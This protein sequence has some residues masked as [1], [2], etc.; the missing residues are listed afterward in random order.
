[1]NFLQE[2]NLL[3]PEQIGFRKN[4]RTTDHLFI[5]KNLMDRYK[6][7]K[8][9]LFI[10]F[11]DFQKAFDTVWHD[12]LFFKL[13]NYGISSKFYSVIRTMYKNVRLAVQ[14]NGALTP[15]FQS[16]VGVRQGD[17]LS[18]SLFNLFINDLP[19]I[20]K[21]CCPAQFG[22]MSLP[23]LLYADDLAIFSESETGMQRALHNLGVY[24]KKWKLTV[25]TTKTKIMII[26]KPPKIGSFLLSNKAID[27]VESYSYLGIE[28]NNS[29]DFE[30]AKSNLY[31]KGL[32]VYFKLV[33]SMSPLPKAS[34]M[35]HL[36]DHL[37]K[38]IL[39]YN[40]EIWG[41]N[42]RQ[43]KVLIS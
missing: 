14:C 24:C 42:F 10:C 3:A 20:F 2:R 31:K 15:F 9:S 40:C 6:K 17:N 16:H 12:G 28:F 41:L 19:Q 13:R 36:F 37:I 33:R 29:C 7:C 4:H 8:K 21:D 27:I 30:L 11:V 35:L 18:P 39:F 26:N 43:S 34:T 25:N 38:P 23:C 32:K 1:M 5:V 22:D